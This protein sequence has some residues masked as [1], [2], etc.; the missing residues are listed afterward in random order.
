M[1]WDKLR[2]FRA[3]AAAGSFTSAGRE[4]QLSQ[5]SVSRHISGLEEQLGVALFHRHSRGLI[6]TEQGESLFETAQD[7]FSKLIF[8]VRNQIFYHFFPDL[9]SFITIYELLKFSF[10]LFFNS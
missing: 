7:V 10:L 1:D 3:V 2:V 4:L 9:I 5:S 6:L 8:I